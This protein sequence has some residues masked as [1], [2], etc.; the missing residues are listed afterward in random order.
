[1]SLTLCVFG[2]DLASRC[3]FS[4]VHGSQEAEVAFKGVLI[5]RMLYGLGHPRVNRSCGNPLARFCTRVAQRRRRKGAV[6]LRRSRPGS[7]TLRTRN[8]LRVKV[9]VSFL[10]PPLFLSQHIPGMK[11]AQVHDKCNYPIA[12]SALHS[13][14]SPQI[15]SASHI[16][17]R[18]PKL[19]HRAHT[20]GLTAIYSLW[21]L[22]HLR[23][24][25]AKGTPP[26]KE[27][28]PFSSCIRKL[29]NGLVCAM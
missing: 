21:R 19:M 17:S 2:A 3:V 16:N 18:P 7:S 12:K 15:S 27:G 26:Q 25:L 9:K 10:Q 5:S 29:I 6:L 20:A 13:R 24:P 1:M 28:V 22:P 11:C 8:G 23:I 4:A 14:G